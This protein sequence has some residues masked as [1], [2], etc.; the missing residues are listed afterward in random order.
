MG[1]ID[2]CQVSVF[3]GYVNGRNGTLIDE[4]LYLPKERTED[5][6][7]RRE[8]GVLDEVTFKTEAQ[9]GKE[10]RLHAR[11]NGVPLGWVSM[12]SFYGDL[13]GFEVDTLRNYCVVPNVWT[14]YTP[15][16]SLHS[17]EII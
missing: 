14:L 3:L 6:P 5:L 15:A 17:S 1:L 8:A 16:Q 10:M 9:L 2:N 11:D 13:H 7:R 4:Q 12:D